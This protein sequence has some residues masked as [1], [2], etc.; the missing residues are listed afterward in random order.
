MK[1][2]MIAVAAVTLAS[3]AHANTT[4]TFETLPGMGNAPG[5]VVP[6]ASQLSNQFLASDGV[7]FSSGAG[8]VAVVDHVSGCGASCTPTPPNIIGG[9]AADGRLSYSTPITAS[10]FS[11]SDPSVMATTDFVRVLGDLRPLRSGTIFLEAYDRFG[12]LLLSTSAA[13]DGP[14]GTGASLSLSIAGIHSVR[15]YSDNQ[16]VGF[17]NFEFG[18]LVASAVP[19]PAS[20][21]LMIA[22]FGLVGGTIRRRRVRFAIG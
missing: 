7:S 13:D 22:G 4:I 18:E 20:W 6:S 15:F 10:F 16:T 14:D 1:H 17:D 11:T 3:S 19:E 9:V 5:A 8:Y 12:N 21:A 2:W